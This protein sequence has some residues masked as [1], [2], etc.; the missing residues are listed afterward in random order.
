[1]RK[2]LIIICAVVALFLGGALL[3]QQVIW[4]PAQTEDVDLSTAVP[5]E[6]PGWTIEDHELADSE[7][8]QDRVEEILQFTQALFRSYRKG[9]TEIAVYIAYWEPRTMP[10]RM[11]QAHTPDICW[12]RNGWEVEDSEF[13]V[14]LDAEGMPLKPAEFRIMT[15]DPALQYVYYWHTV[16]DRIYVNRIVGTW[17]R[18]DPIK[19]LFK[20]GLNQRREQF[21][22]RLSSNHPFE[23]IWDNPDFQL[24]LKD[25]AKLAIKEDA[26]PEAP[27]VA[28][29]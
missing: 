5:S 26:I 27:T 17:D 21:F 2:A 18:W 6:L 28:Q 10:V 25:L 12:V 1:M 9:D 29:S 14:Q 11:V 24:I 8:M 22:I 4:A 15:K 13:S 23:E 7:E 16:G 20:F 3:Y 19:S